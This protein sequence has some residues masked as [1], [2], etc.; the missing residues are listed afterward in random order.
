MPVR[1]PYET[2]GVPPTATD[3]QLRAAY[4]RLVQLHHPDHNQGSPESAR[5]FEEVQEA[6]AQ[7]LRERKQAPPR[8]TVPPADPDLDSRLHDLEKQVLKAQERA[9]RAAREAA[10]DARD[11]ARQAAR[12]PTASEGKRPTDEELGYYTTEDSFTSI[13]ADARSELAQHLAHAQEHPVA[14]RVKD[15]IDGL[16]DLASKLDRKNH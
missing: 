4:R 16:D 15:L 8:Q 11:A 7:V 12:R 10:R 9:R 14:K 5:R 3:A 1:S 2:L 13:L 6:Y